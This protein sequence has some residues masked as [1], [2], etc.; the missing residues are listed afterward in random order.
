[1]LILGQSWKGGREQG[2][3][4]FMHGV[5]GGGRDILKSKPLG[6]V[7][8]LE[9]NGAGFTNLFYYLNTPVKRS[10]LLMIFIE[11]KRKKF[12]NP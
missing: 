1:M 12:R 3:F 8:T 11:L 10:N 9:F 6:Q 4:S 7:L 5:E 2:T